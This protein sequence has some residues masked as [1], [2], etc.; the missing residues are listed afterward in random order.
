MAFM[1][2]FLYWASSFNNSLNTHYE[3]NPVWAG[4]NSAVSKQTGFLPLR[5]WS[6]SF[7]RGWLKMQASTNESEFLG[8][9]YFPWVTIILMN[10]RLLHPSLLHAWEKEINSVSFCSWC[11]GTARKGSQR[12]EGLSSPWMTTSRFSLRAALIPGFLL[13]THKLM[14]FC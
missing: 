3:P 13:Y 12:W 10:I 5:H 7:S 8:V 11:G 4:E 1:Q 9:T 14:N 6:L 2:W